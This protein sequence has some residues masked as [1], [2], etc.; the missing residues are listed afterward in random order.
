MQQ[1]IQYTIYTL[2]QDNDTSINDED[3]VYNFRYWFIF[4]I[5]LIIKL[6]EE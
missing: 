3:M 1:Y 6:F 4:V 2:Y 5:F